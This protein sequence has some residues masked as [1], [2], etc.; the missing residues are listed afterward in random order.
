MGLTNSEIKTYLTLLSG[1]IMNARDIYQ[2]SDVPFGKIYDVL[3]SLEKRGLISIQKSRPKMFMVNEPKIGLKNLISEKEKNLQAL[4]EQASNVEEELN[5][6]HHKHPEDSLFWTVILNIDFNKKALHNLHSKIFNETKK[7]L[8]VYVPSLSLINK[9]LMMEEEYFSRYPELLEK[10]IKMKFITGQFNN[11]DKSI[12][13]TIFQH[14]IAH[15]NFTIKHSTIISQPFVIIDSEKIFVSIKNPVKPDEYLA[16]L[17]LWKKDFAIELKNK[18]ENIWEQ[19]H[20]ISL[21]N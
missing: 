11:K 3:Y 12:L 2:K 8:L 17:Y 7:E 13:K 19:A 5:K 4:I 15:K 6:I 18:F 20:L 10:G 1:G 21:T 14:I 9:F 16:G